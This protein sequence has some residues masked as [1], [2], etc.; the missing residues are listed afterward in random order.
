MADLLRYLQYG[1]APDVNQ[2]FLLANA[3]SS[4]TKL[5][6]TQNINKILEHHKG[7]KFKI[8]KTGDAEFRADQIDYREAPYKFLYVLYQHTSKSTISSTEE[9]YIRKYKALFPR[10]CQNK[11]MHSAGGMVSKTAYYYVYL[12]I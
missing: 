4:Y 11:Q 6:I 7:N 5:L 8:G 9:Y 12:V 2:N 3:M 10:R 1:Y